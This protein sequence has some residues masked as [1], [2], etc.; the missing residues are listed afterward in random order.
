[1]WGRSDVPQHTVG[2]GVSQPRDVSGVNQWLGVKKK[3]F[4]L[5]Q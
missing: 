4:T 3:F 5:P 1:M 2:G